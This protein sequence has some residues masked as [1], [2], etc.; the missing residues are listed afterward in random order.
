M[1]VIQQFTFFSNPLGFDVPEGF[2]TLLD[3]VI[4]SVN[5]V[6]ADGDSFTFNIIPNAGDPIFE[7]VIGTGLIQFKGPNLLDYDTE[8]K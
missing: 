8:Q 5:A 2:E 4:G 3:T 1:F 6:D 7:I